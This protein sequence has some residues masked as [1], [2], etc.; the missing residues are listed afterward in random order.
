MNNPMDAAKCLVDQLRQSCQYEYSMQW[1]GTKI[2]RG[3]TIGGIAVGCAQHGRITGVKGEELG[4][5]VRT[6]EYD[7]PDQDE[8]A[9][10]VSTT[11]AVEVIAPNGSVCNLG[12]EN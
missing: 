10:L 5:Y 6:K 4:Y 12:D 1:L 11:G 7:G 3:A 8:H 9:M 2:P